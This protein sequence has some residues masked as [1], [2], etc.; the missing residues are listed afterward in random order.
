MLRLIK[1]KFKK[2]AIGDVIADWEFGIGNKTHVVLL[3]ATNDIINVQVRRSQQTIYDGVKT[4][5]KE[6][7]MSMDDIVKFSPT[8]SN[9]EYMIEEIM[10][11]E[12]NW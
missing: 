5:G 7:P 6:I 3:K 4:Y 9:L 10:Y 1:H 11:S 8:V 12:V 2:S